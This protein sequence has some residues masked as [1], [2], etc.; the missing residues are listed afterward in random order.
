MDR[1]CINGEWRA[2]WAEYGA[3][4]L[5]FARQ[6]AALIADAED[7]VQEAFVRF[8]RAHAADPGLTPTL[9]FQMVRR[10]AID[11]ARRTASRAAR[12]AEAVRRTADEPALFAGE[13]AD[14]DRIEVVEAALRA[15]PTAQREVLVLKIW[16]GL[17]FEQV[18]AVLEVSPNTAASR[19]RYGLNQ[20]RT[21]LSPVSQ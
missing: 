21:L 20:L 13:H 8:W 16:G 6:Q 4:L 2:L 9:L 1:E 10:I 14:R 15:L 7:I 19:Y 3:R 18:G 17:T 5:V 11:Y 12:E